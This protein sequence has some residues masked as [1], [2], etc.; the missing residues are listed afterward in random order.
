MHCA[1]LGECLAAE[2]RRGRSWTGR[3]MSNGRD[4]ARPLLRFEPQ[5]SGAAA[6]E[7][8]RFSARQL[9]EIRG[10]AADALDVAAD[11]PNKRRD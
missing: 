4:D 7:C 6:G 11:L 10:V 5:P 3:V 8:D 2:L 1:Q 9:G